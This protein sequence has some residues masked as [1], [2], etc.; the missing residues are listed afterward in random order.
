MYFLICSSTQNVRINKTQ[1]CLLSSFG[2]KI[3]RF[4]QFLTVVEEET[5]L[6]ALSFWITTHPVC[7][8]LQIRFATISKIL[9]RN[10]VFFY[11]IKWRPNLE[12]ITVT[13]KTKCRHLRIKENPLEN[14]NKYYALYITWSKTHLMQVDKAWI[15][16]D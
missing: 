12:K 8:S 9:S 15:I 6:K 4:L 2:R 16:Y 7:L 1:L 13:N 11:W 14:L 10:Q 3:N 5:F